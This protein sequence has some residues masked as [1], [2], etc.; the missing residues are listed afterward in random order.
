MTTR[1]ITTKSGSTIQIEM[2]REVVDKTSYCDGQRTVT[3][4]E[5]IE[6]TDITLRDNTG[7][8]IGSG[9]GIDTN[10]DI[11]ADIKAHNVVGKIGRAWITQ[12]SANQIN[13]ILAELEIE[14]PKTDEYIA[15]KAAAAKAQA[16]HDTW[17][18]S[19]EMVAH[20]KLMREMD[21]PNSDL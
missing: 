15:I 1:T 2:V 8:Y 18:N 11:P 7:K 17:Y 4:R 14:N 6:Y 5:I 9:N 10:I 3:G 16:D 20:R 21:D 19:P 12:E 13:A